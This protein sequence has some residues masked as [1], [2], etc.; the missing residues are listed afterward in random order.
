MPARR[1]QRRRTATAV[2]V[3]L[4]LVGIATH[5]P[6]AGAQSGVIIG[7]V[8]DDADRDGV[9]DTGEAPFPGR[10]LWVERAT[11]EYV[12]YVIT[13]SAGR[14]SIGGLGEGQYRLWM[15]S[16]DWEGLRDD[17]VPST[18]GSL[19]FER[20]VSLEGTTTSAD[21][22]LRRIVRSTN[23][24]APISTVTGPDGLTVSSY[25][26]VVHAQAIY[27]ELHTGSLLGGERPRTTVRFDLGDTN[28]THTLWGGSEGAYTGYSATVDTDYVSWLV[29]GNK[30][31]FH[32][33]GHAWSMYNAIMVHQTES[34]DSYLEARGV[35]GEPR[36]AS[37][38]FWDPKEMI[39]EDYRQLFGSG[40]ALTYPQ[41]NSEIPRP[42]DVPGLADWLRTT[43]TSAASGGPTP[44]PAPDPSQGSLAVMGLAVRPDP[45][46]TSGTVSFELSSTASVTVRVLDASGRTV[47][48][49][50][51]AAS[52][53]A[54][55]SDVAWDRRTDAGRKA[56]AG[57][58][59]ASVV[60]V[61]RSGT[62]A[63]A[64]IGFSVVDTKVRAR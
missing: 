36:V 6:V 62:T 37:D 16:A 25:N 55:G 61:D 43:F 4:S 51:E 30:S 48:T 60:A 2:A 58:Y 56:R 28:V 53:A 24:D 15:S 54:G 47:R 17:W 42:V 27:D 31:L 49:L 46:V 33:Y 9:H 8:Y 10:Q 5:V 7:A 57:A 44:P 64:Q 20:V 3:L 32:E 18:S 35:L 23:V 26:D 1:Q 41:A 11:G 45:V 59:T 40:Q 12:G 21:L 34:L 50:L 14:F 13:D 22:G 52:R 19:R 38:V 63:R 39:A 29:V